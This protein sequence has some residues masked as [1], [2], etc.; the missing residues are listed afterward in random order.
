MFDRHNIHPKFAGIRRLKL[1]SEH[2]QYRPA[3]P[4]ILRRDRHCPKLHLKH[5]DPAAII[6]L[7][8]IEPAIMKTIGKQL[9]QFSPSQVVYL[10]FFGMPL[11]S[12]HT[13]DWRETLFARVDLQCQNTTSCYIDFSVRVQQSVDSIAS[14]RET[15]FDVRRRLQR[16]YFCRIQSI[17]RQQEHLPSLNRS[18]QNGLCFSLSQKLLSRA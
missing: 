17:H 14:A 10:S 9:F 7:D 4:P 15:H 16:V 1:H 18:L 3:A 2:P 5:C 11:R 12:G 6:Y 8:L 13:L